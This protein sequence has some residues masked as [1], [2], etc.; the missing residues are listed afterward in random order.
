MESCFRLALFMAATQLVAAIHTCRHFDAPSARQRLVLALWA[1]SQAVPLLVI[2][3]GVASF[4]AI[5]RESD[6]HTDAVAQ[7]LQLGVAASAAVLGGAHYTRDA[8]FFVTQALS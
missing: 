1:L 7:Q 4:K 2:C 8:G 3:F 6:C 5:V